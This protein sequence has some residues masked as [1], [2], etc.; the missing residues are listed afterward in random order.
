VKKIYTKI[1]QIAGP[2]AEIKG[3]TDIG[4]REIAQF[5]GFGMGQVIKLNED[6]VIVQSLRGTLGMSTKQNVYFLGH[7]MTIPYD[8]RLLLGRRFNGI[9]QPLDGKPQ[10]SSN[11][12][13]SV[14]AAVINPTAREMASGYV[15]TGIPG[16]D[17]TNTI[18]RSQKIPI[19]KRPEESVN[20]VLGRIITQSEVNDRRP[21]VVI[22]GGM[23]SIWG[24]VVG[25]TVLVVFPELLRFLGMPSAI[26][27]QTRQMIYGL[28]LVILMIKR[29]QGLLGRYRF[30]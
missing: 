13:I 14:Q 6:N 28:L 11:R 19:F 22:F 1:E 12:M 15:Q 5:A 10:I 16:I 25:A 18:V 9:F 3:A 20:K 23:G 30:K 8:S 27:A 4:N 21:F 17:G 7:E 29:P 24:S 26:E 2:I